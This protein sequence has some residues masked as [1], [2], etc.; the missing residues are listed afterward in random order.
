MKDGL[1]G[2]AV[3]AYVDDRYIVDEFF[4]LDKKPV[5]AKLRVDADG[6]KRSFIYGDMRFTLDDT[7]YLSSEGLKKGKRFTGATIGP[8]VKGNIECSFKD[9]KIKFIEC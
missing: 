2:V 4:A 3:K 1:Y 5:T 8:Y 6:I 9:W 7:S